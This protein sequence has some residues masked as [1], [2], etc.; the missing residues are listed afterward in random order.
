M[1]LKMWSSDPQCPWGPIWFLQSHGLQKALQSVPGRTRVVKGAKA[2]PLTLSAHER[3][4]LNGGM[5]QLVAAVARRRGAA[6]HAAHLAA[7]LRP[8]SRRAVHDD[9]LG[10]AFSHP[11][12]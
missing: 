7:Y 12:A 3:L 1:S 5:L 8:C 6:Q 9:Y 10:A 2:G 4:L 11:T